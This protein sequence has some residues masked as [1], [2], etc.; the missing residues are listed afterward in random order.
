M[1]QWTLF[2]NDFR[3]IDKNLNDLIDRTSAISVHLVDRSGQLITPAKPSGRRHTPAP[4]VERTSGP[5]RAFT[6]CERPRS[7][8]ASP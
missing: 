7:T 5:S 2:E 6:A 8:P 1:P 3:A 4:Q